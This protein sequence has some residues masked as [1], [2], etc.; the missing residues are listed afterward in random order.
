MISEY[1]CSL[2]HEFSTPMPLQSISSNLPIFSFCSESRKSPISKLV[3]SYLSSHPN[4]S[5]PTPLYSW[6]WPR[7]VYVCSGIWNDGLNSAGCFY[8][9]DD[10]PLNIVTAAKYVMF[11]FSM[12]KLS[13]SKLLN[14]KI[15]LGGIGGWRKRRALKRLC[16]TPRPEG[17]ACTLST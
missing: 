1:E 12:P 17:V 7:V 15:I 11:S 10:P 8:C 6:I 9:G 3:L 4:L 2:S 16:G 14:G 5:H 13:P